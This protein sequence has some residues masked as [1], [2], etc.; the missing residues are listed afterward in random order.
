MSNLGAT[1]HAL[2]KKEGRLRALA[3]DCV[4]EVNAELVSSATAMAVDL[5]RYPPLLVNPKNG[6]L[7][8]YQRTG[9]LGRNWQVLASPFDFALALVKAG[10]ALT[11]SV[12]DNVTDTG[13]GYKN[14]PQ[15][16]SQD[17]IG[18]EYAGYVQDENQQRPIHRGR[19]TTI[20]QARAAHVPRLRAACRAAIKRAVQ[21]SGG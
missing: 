2:T 11:V 6:K 19:W 17:F 10:G 14:Y 20:Q 18:Q 3:H 7:Q 9:N 8:R 12:V 5:R 4:R 21:Q 16:T 1:I 13:E 15:G